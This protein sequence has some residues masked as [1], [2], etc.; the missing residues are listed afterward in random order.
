MKNVSIFFLL[1]LIPDI[2]FAQGSAFV[3]TPQSMTLLPGSVKNV[4]VVDDD[5][6]CCASG[7]L[8]KARRSGAQVLDFMTDTSFGRLEEGV[9]YVVRHPG[10]GNIFFTKRDKHGDS[11]LYCCTN[12]G[13]KDEKTK[14][15]RIGGGLL[16]RG[17]TVEHPTFSKDGNIMIF[18][19]TEH[20]GADYD[21]WY[22]HFDGEEWDKP[23]SLDSKVNT[24]GDEVS[25]LMYGDYL[26]FATNGHDA[27]S[28]HF[29][30]YTTRVRVESKKELEPGLI[31]G[32]TEEVTVW[33]VESGSVQRLP[34]PINVLSSDDFDMAVDTHTGCGYWVSRRNGNESDS[35]LFS[36]TGR[37]E[38][39]MLWGKVTDRMGNPLAGVKVMARQGKELA[40]VSTTEADGFYQMYLQADCFYYLDYKLDNYFVE[41]ETINTARTDGEYLI[42][43]VQRNITLDKLPLGQRIMFDDI[44]GPGVDVELSERGIELLAPLV[45]FLNDNSS[46]WVEMTLVND[47]TADRDFNTLLTDQRILSLQSYLF[48]LL[49]LNVKIEVT[50]GCEG[51]E[52]CSDATGLSRLTVLI[53]SDL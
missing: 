23:R 47:L 26:V 1:V 20:Q 40:C 25:P 9:E 19:S 18:S 41:S 32:K 17:M 28:N 5:L 42:A 12:Y 53:Y 10:N 44:F 49:P 22:T 36:L 45:K 13:R 7:V 27:D 14:M 51:K 33:K 50:N 48:P 4:T 30:L 34:Y 52:G 46:M 38:G 43:D 31:P 39:V 24:K 2:L 35:M 11:W 37:L 21:L 16:N 29:S 3:A 6:F 8:M 15:L